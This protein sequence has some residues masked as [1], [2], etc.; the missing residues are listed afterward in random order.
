MKL[1]HTISLR[2][3]TLTT[4]V[5]VFWSLF[6]YFKMMDEINDEVDDS[7]EDYAEAIIIRSLAG[8]EIPTTS[9]GSN[10]QFFQKPVSTDYAQQH[11]HIR[12]ADRN[13]F[14]Y[15]KQEFEP[16]RVLTYIYQDRHGQYYELEVS[17]P[18][19]EKDDLRGT[20]FYSILSLFVA[21]L[22]SILA[23][24]VFSIHRTMRP[25]RRLLKWVENF[26]IGKKNQALDNPTRIQEFAQLNK[27]VEESMMRSQKLFER[28]KNFLGTASHELQTP[29]AATMNRLESIL[30][31]ETLSEK[32]TGDLLKAIH[33]L[34]NMSQL[35][36]SLLMFS[37]I[38]NGQF[39]DTQGIDFMKLAEEILPELQ[40]VYRSRQ[41][42]VE[43]RSEAPFVRLI[44]PTLA[45]MMLTNLLKNAFLH[46]KI[47]GNLV[48]TSRHN[49]FTI[50]ND[51]QQSLDA[52]RIFEPF[53]REQSD[54][55]HDNQEWTS[56]GIGLALVQT[57]CKQSNLQINYCFEE[58]R[59]RFQIC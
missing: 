44:D 8:E 23:I 54:K 48:V 2:L 58:G 43:I 59:H 18:H 34:E 14:I 21:L 10:N 41:I 5:L 40:I 3:L 27:A 13:V 56:T 15:E 20:I 11:K 4:I 24:N 32:Q 31:E 19:I 49:D 51:G 55:N 36:R 12:Y 39:N 22:L 52:N 1:L 28:Q 30:D 26:Q 29:I 53:Y 17:T 50:S 57:I 45:R 16:A 25:L 47:G 37:K 35:N 38:E 42:K 6:F 46:N 9:I 33:S 7:L